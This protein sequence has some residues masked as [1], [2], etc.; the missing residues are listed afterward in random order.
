MEYR[1]VGEKQLDISKEKLAALRREFQEAK[2]RVRAAMRDWRETHRLVL[3]QF[4][5]PASARS[6]R[7]VVMRS[8]RHGQ[9]EPVRRENRVW[10]TPRH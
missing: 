9:L 7:M 3:A 1:K 4:T 2:K 5:S 10:S 8:G 6:F